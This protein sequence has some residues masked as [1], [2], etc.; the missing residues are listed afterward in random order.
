MGSAACAADA[1]A[2][3]AVLG[4][5]GKQLIPCGAAYMCMCVCDCDCAFNPCERVLRAVLFCG[6]RLHVVG[7]LAFQCVGLSG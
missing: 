5:A 3:A 7:V 2:H 4:V 6:R 1:G